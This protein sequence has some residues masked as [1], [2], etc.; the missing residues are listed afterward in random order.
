MDEVHIQIE[1]QCDGTAEDFAALFAQLDQA[2]A[3]HCM[4]DAYA[5]MA[6]RASAKPRPPAGWPR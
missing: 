1:Q 5:L 6:R 2:P 3:P 4:H